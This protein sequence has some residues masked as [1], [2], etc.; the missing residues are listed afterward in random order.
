[1]AGSSAHHKTSFHFFY[2]SF[3]R[4]VLVPVL[5]ASEP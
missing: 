1:M 3:E 4:P 2:S 5:V